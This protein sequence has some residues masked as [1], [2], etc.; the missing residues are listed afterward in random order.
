MEN[1]G[2]FRVNVKGVHEKKETMQDQ[3]LRWLRSKRIPLTFF[4][5]SGVR[6]RGVVTGGGYSEA[7][8]SGRA[9][10]DR[11]DVSTVMSAGS[12]RLR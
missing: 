1:T 11:Y 8:L 4:L 10:D 3:Y 12:V 7:M 2:V 9:G 5:A 6:I